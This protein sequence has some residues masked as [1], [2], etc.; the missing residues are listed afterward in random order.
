MKINFF[1]PMNQLGY[2]IHAYNTIKEFEKL[3][4]QICLL[5]PFGRAH[6]LNEDV[7]RWLAAREKFST[8]N[9]S[10]MMFHEDFLPHFSGTPRIGF[11]VFEKEKFEEFEKTAMRSCDALLVPSRWGKNVLEQQG[12]KNIHVVPEGF[13]PVDFPLFEEKQSDNPELFT[14][15]HVGKF[16]ER[17]GT[18]QVVECFFRALERE[19]ARL[20]M[21]IHNPFIDNY[22]ILLQK[23]EDLG[24]VS[25]NGGRM[26]RR[27]GLSILFT[28][29]VAIHSQMSNLYRSADCGI[30][31][32]RAEGWGLPILECIATGTPVIAGNWTGQSEYIEGESILEIKKFTRAPAYDGHFY[33]GDCGEWNVPDNQRLIELI[34][35]AYEHRGLRS[36]P[37]WVDYVSKIRERFTWHEAAKKLQAA[38]REI[39]GL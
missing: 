37:R 5:P 11:P 8:H 14:F 24:F 17:K 22:K 39:T 32:T 2:G 16:E 21:H 38:L 28:E 7:E 20:I 25:T 6:F 12:C 23:L 36:H 33:A 19:E 29:Q 3:G 15:V 18:L 35:F 27:L 34:Q 10:V 30:F 31:P 26:W 9:P 1:A 13:D 4:N